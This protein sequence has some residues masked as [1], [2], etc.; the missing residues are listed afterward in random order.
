MGLPDLRFHGSEVRI[1]FFFHRMYLNG[2][3]LRM[4]SLEMLKV[5]GDKQGERIQDGRTALDC[6]LS[7]A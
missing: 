2:V 6:C 3:D 1:R 4:G 5:V 7:N